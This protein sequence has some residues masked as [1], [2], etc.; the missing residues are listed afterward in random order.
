MS[1]TCTG[2][3]DPLGCRPPPSLFVGDGARSGL[4]GRATCPVTACAHTPPP[5]P[6]V[7][8][9]GTSAQFATQTVSLELT[10]C[11][12]TRGP[13]T[14]HTHPHTRTLQ[15]HWRHKGWRCLRRCVSGINGLAVPRGGVDVVQQRDGNTASGRRVRRR[16]RTRRRRQ[17]RRRR[18]CT[19]MRHC[20]IASSTSGVEAALGRVRLCRSTAYNAAAGIFGCDNLQYGQ[21]TVPGSW[22]PPETLTEI[23]S[24]SVF[25]RW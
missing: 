1:A 18:S 25:R 21:V 12:L 17:R 23:R 9:V 8:Q 3:G 24:W 19:T 20:L 15:F 16:Q 7:H 4:A 10:H 13:S 11:P 14:P 22:R 5:P 2:D 6:R